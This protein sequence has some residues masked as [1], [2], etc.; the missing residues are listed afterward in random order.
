[1]LF[2]PIRKKIEGSDTKTVEV[3]FHEKIYFLATL[4]DDL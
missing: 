2:H 4:V 3:L 1:M